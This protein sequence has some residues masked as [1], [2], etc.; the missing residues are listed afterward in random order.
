LRPWESAPRVETLLNERCVIFDLDGTLIESEQIWRE[1]RHEFVIA[2]GGRWHDGAAA[3]MIGMR[4]EEWSCYIHD[5]LGVELPPAEIAERVVKAVVERVRKLPP[6]P[7]A[8]EALARLAATFRLGLA[9]SA[10][11]PV[12]QTVLEQAGWGKLFEVVVSADEVARGKPAPDVYLRALALMHADP[13]HAVAIEDSAN[14]IRSAH[15]A[16]LAVIAIPNHEFPP[17][18][19]AL[20]L[21]SRVLPNLDALSVEA[22]AGP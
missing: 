2:N 22:V 8:N 15:A 13:R 4:S 1:V 20:A 11:M 10:A 7:G 3:A 19:A 16:K 18:A 17:D 21:A 9:T 12:A 5:E 6:L 14:G